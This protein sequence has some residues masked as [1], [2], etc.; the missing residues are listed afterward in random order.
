M[1]AGKCSPPRHPGR[2]GTPQ[3]A[4]QLPAGTATG[5]AARGTTGSVVPP[6]GGGEAEAGNGT[7]S[8]SL[9]PAA[10]NGPRREPG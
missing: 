2:R 6:P 8:P 7:T 9:P 5:E 1:H 3:A 4:L 10:A